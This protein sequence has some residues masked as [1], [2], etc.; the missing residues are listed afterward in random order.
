MLYY[1][2]DNINHNKD[3]ISDFNKEKIDEMIKKRNE[4]I[5]QRNTLD[6][7]ITY[8]NLLIGDNESG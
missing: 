7:E 4:L 8:L 6:R 1:N 5:I 2:Q 3:I